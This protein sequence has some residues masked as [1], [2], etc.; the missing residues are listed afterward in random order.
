MIKL[1]ISDSL[2]ISYTV[3]TSRT[4]YFHISNT[5]LR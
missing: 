5:I 1:P 4:Y 3:D 2:N